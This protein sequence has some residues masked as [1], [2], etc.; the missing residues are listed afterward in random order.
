MANL[1]IGFSVLMSLYNKESPSSLDLCFLSLY[2]QTTKANEIVLVLDGFIDENLKSI[3]CYW[4]NYLPLKIVP[5]ESNV[6]LG[7]AL[8]IGLQHCSYD[9][10]ARMDTDDQC[11]KDRFERQIKIL[12]ER[13]ELSIVGSDII[14]YDENIKIEISR[15]V[16]PHNDSGIKRKAIYGNPFNHM[17]V[18]F[19][20]DRIIS[21]GGYVHHLFME[22]YNLWLRLI[23]SNNMMENMA[24]PLVKVRAGQNMLGRRRGLKYIASEWEL[25]LLKNKLGINNII[26]G[27]FMFCARAIPRLIPTF[28][29]T[30]LYK[31]IRSKKK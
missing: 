18:M 8:N 24:I 1:D 14:E 20:K 25:Y 6:G 26:F 12:S 28:L 21:A 10:I 30:Y 15:R 23:A 27:F 9:F 11:V 19:R 13:D 3:I 16:V 2:E 5:L 7:R 4:E 29:L 22:D 17:T 31:L